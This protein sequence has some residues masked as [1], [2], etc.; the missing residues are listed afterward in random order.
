MSVTVTYSV[1]CDAPDVD[2]P[3]EHCE[4]WFSHLGVALSDVAGL[5]RQLDGRGW[6]Y[7]AGKFT[8]PLHARKA[9][10]DGR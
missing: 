1:T 3:G 2:D 7:R 5:R 4:A 8:C 10:T 6:T 9:K